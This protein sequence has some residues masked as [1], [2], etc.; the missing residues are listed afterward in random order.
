MASGRPHDGIAKLAACDPNLAGEWVSLRY[1]DYH[2]H[3][4]ADDLK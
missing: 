4:P 1:A 2:V 3:N